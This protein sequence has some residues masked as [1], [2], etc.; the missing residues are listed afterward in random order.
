MP[1]NSLYDYAKCQTNTINVK[2][3]HFGWQTNLTESH[4]QRTCWIGLQEKCLLQSDDV[5]GHVW[6]SVLFPL[7]TSHT[8]FFSLCYWVPHKHSQW[9]YQI[10][11]IVN[12]GFSATLTWTNTTSN[13]FSPLKASVAPG[14]WFLSGWN[15]KASFLYA[16]FRSSSDASLLSPRIS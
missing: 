7:H 8:A 15:F 14:A 6:M 12:D 2:M 10:G 11:R 4:L 3:Y 1:C 9:L 16:F 13:W 5:N